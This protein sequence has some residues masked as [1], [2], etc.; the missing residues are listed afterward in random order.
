MHII[1]HALSL[2]VVVKCITVMH[3]RYQRSQARRPEQNTAL[4]SNI[5]QF[6]TA[7]ISGKALKQWSRKCYVSTVHNSKN[8]RLRIK[9]VE[10][11][12]LIV[13]TGHFTTAKT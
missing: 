5:E 8:I 3:L 1:L 13:T 4:N 10:Q 7:K 9:T 2:L 6:I 12:I 11:N